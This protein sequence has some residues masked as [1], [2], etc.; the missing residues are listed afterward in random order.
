[1]GVFGRPFQNPQR[2]QRPSGEGC[3]VSFRRDKN[4]RIAGYKSN[5][6]CSPA[7]IKAIMER[8][9]EEEGGEEE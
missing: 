9:N 2:A 7:E 5:G 4:G 3:K 8:S 1:M 6:L